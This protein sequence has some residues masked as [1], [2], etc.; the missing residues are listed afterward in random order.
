MPVTAE[1]MTITVKARSR[2][3]AWVLITKAIDSGL[4]AS[5]TPDLSARVAVEGTAGQLADFLAV[6][7]A[8]DLLTDAAFAEALLGLVRSLT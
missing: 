5:G 1:K 8:L 2:G 7:R 3:K 4:G 6:A